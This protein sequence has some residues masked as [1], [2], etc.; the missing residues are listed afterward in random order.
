M[1]ADTLVEGGIA[2]TLEGD[3]A[4][5]VALWTVSLIDTSGV[6]ESSDREIE[7]DQVICGGRRAGDAGDDEEDQCQDGIEEAHCGVGMRLRVREKLR[8]WEWLGT[9]C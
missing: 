2:A 7:R 9:H 6:V 5:A 1:R 4:T 3:D 8:V